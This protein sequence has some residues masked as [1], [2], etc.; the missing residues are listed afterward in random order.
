[1]IEPIYGIW[2]SDDHD[3]SFDRWRRHLDGRRIE[4]ASFADA[5][6]AAA[7]LEAKRTNK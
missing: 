7:E 3:P 4:F 2:C 1:M 6:K 5:E